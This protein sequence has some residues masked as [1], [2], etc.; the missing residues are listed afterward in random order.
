M[1]KRT[2][3]TTP[4]KPRPPPPPPS[5]RERAHALELD[6][7]LG[8]ILRRSPNKDAPWVGGALQPRGGVDGIG[9]GGG[10]HAPRPLQQSADV[11]AL[12]RRRQQT[13]GR[14]LRGASAHP[15][16]HGEF[17]QPVLLPR[18]LVHGDINSGNV[19]FDGDPPR[20]SGI[21]DFGDMVHS[22]LV[23]EVAV[24]AAYAVLGKVDPLT[25]LARVVA[26]HPEFEATLAGLLPEVTFTAEE[27]ALRERI[28]AIDTARRVEVMTV[29]D[30][31]RRALEVTGRDADLIVFA[32]PVYWWHLCAQMKTFVDRM[33]PMLTF[34]ALFAVGAFLTDPMLF[35]E[36]LAGIALLA[37][38]RSRR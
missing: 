1:P 21:I 22:Y 32:A 8:E 9:D 30:A 38:I 18:Q 36:I 10:V 37:M 29:L 34:W 4:P 2:A 16:V 20:V 19:L 14:E 27:T 33:H 17:S 13:H 5:L 23:G 31:P 26:A 6:C 3:K 12:Q 24:A 35:V 28:D 25:A 7:L 15:V 11:D